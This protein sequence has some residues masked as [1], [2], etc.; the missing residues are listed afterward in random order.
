MRKR[1]LE[2][3]SLFALGLYLV[4][5]ALAAGLLA[6][7]AAVVVIR[8]RDMHYWLPHYVFPSER[9]PVLGPEEPVDV[10]IAI[11][12]HYEPECQHVSRERARERVARWV[13][14]YPKLFDRFRDSSGR[15]PQHTFFFPQD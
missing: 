9:R 13:T 11:G 5:G 10:Y 2:G 14:E 1:R 15:P 8:R 12:D 6:A 4:F 7:A 3:L